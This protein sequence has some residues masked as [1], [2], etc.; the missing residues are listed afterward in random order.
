MK[1][2][3]ILTINDIE[4]TDSIRTIYLIINNMFNISFKDYYLLHSNILRHNTNKTLADYNIVSEST[5]HIHFRMYK[6][7]VKIM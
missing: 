1:N 3:S 2:C 5:I 7:E 4:K 6:N